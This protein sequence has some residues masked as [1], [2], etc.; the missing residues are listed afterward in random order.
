MLEQN[1]RP[2]WR[3]EPEIDAERQRFLRERLAIQPDVNQGIYPFKGVKLTRADV[4]WLLVTHEDGRGPVDWDDEKQ[5][6][7]LGLDLRGA[8]LRHVDLHGLPLARIHGGLVRREWS[9]ATP[10]Q[11]EAAALHLEGADLSEAHLEGAILR[12]AHLQSATLRKA[13]LRDAI[14]YRAN[15]RNAYLREAHLERASLIAANLEGVYLRKV[16]LERADLR[17]AFFDGVSSL[18]ESTLSSPE[19]GCVAIADV[20]WGDLNLSLIDWRQVRILGDE[21]KAR[22]KTR[23]GVTKDRATQLDDYRDAVRANRQL[24]NAMR[25]QGMNEEAVP[26]AYRAQVLQRKVLWLQVLW[27]AEPGQNDVSKR[28][29]RQRLKDVW[30]RVRYFSSYVFSLFLDG[31]AGY[32]YKPGRS[33]MIYLFVI[34]AFSVCYATLGHLSARE[35]LIFSVTSFHGR[36][37]LPGPFTLASPVTA[38]AALEAVIGLFIEISFIATFTQR[39]FGR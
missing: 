4:E 39:F 37:F 14:L 1:V 33:L 23:R 18:E 22:Q 34:A 15:M 16:H 5:R 24:A 35:A 2:G 32:G 28:S 11:R 7:R 30:Q 6:G 38:L 13:S 19:L 20:Q 27:G 31:L 10:E 26:F 25:G 17:N 8:D 12:G 29:L 3:T 36:G 9:H 21:Y